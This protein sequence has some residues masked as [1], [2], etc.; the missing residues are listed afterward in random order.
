MMTTYRRETVSVNR[1]ALAAGLLAV[2]GLAGCGGDPEPSAEPQPY[3]SPEASTT[4]SSTLRSMP[5]GDAGDGGALVPIEPGTYLM[6]SSA[7]S[8]ADFTVTFPKGWTAQ[9]G[10]VFG[11][12]PDQDDE[13]GFS[14]SWSMRSTPTRARVI[15]VM[16]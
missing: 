9:Y 12:H 14:R 7:W 1:L 8:D 5:D 4:P 10:H 16:S 15:V 6:P 13:S 3:A 2:A 11:Q